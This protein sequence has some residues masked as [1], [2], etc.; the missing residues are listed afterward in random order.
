[1]RFVSYIQNALSAYMNQSTQSDILNLVQDESFRNWVLTPTPETDLFWTTYILHNPQ[2]TP[3]VTQAREIILALQIQNPSISDAE[4]HFHIDETL[5]QVRQKAVVEHDT[6]DEYPLNAT[7]QRFWL[8]LT[9]AFVIILAAGLLYY[10]FVS[11]RSGLPSTAQTESVAARQVVKENHSSSPLQVMLPDGSQVTL[12]KNSLLRYPSTFSET[13]REVYLSG[14]AFFSVI[15]NPNKPFLVYAK[16]LTTR[17]LGTSFRVSAYESEKQITVE[18]KSGKVSVYASE[19]TA[20]R[21]AAPKPAFQEVILT[22]NQKVVY[23]REEVRIEKKLVENPVLTIPK[24][25]AAQLVFE[26]APAP[27]VFDAL[28]KAY[29]IEIVY[30]REVMSHCPL[31]ATLS[32]EPLFDKLAVLCKAIEARYELTDGKIVIHSKGCN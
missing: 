27:K 23:S 32:D 8:R 11:S 9:A 22:P 16:E 12:Q 29:S 7:Y 1:M 13:R 26:D 3:A 14:E 10:Y 15:R 31:T 18:V 20:S 30:D 25:E 24:Q 6:S 5:K 2:Q 28:E 19:D 21:Q 4:V 17:V